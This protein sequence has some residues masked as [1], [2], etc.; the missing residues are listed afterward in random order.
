MRRGIISTAMETIDFQKKD[1]FP[2]ALSVMFEELMDKVKRNVYKSSNETRRS[3][4]KE[5][6]EN[7]IYDR[8]GIKTKV[9]LGAYTAG[10]VIP[11]LMN[12]NHSFNE[13]A[14]TWREYGL[15]AD[16]EKALANIKSKEGT[17][18][19][20]R[21][22]LGGFF[23]EFEHNM[24]L[25]VK[26]WVDIGLQPMEGVAIT[27]HEIG[28]AFTYYEFSDR[29]SS[30]NRVL[31][32]LAKEVST[33]NDPKKKSYILKDLD[34]GKKLSDSDID[35]IINSPNK[36]IIGAR[37]FKLMH[38]SVKDQMDMLYYN[39]TTSEQM[40]DN[41]AAKFGVGRY[42][43]S[44]L[45]RLSHAYFDPDKYRSLRILNT[46]IDL[47]KA[48]VLIGFTIFTL[49][50]PVL[51][52]T[53]VG[54][55]SIFMGVLGLL[56][57]YFMI[58]VGLWSERESNQ[59]MTYDHLKDRYTRVRQQAIQELKDTTLDPEY[60]KNRLQDIELIDKAIE[61]TVTYRSVFNL[62]FR[63]VS[64]DDRDAKATIEINRDLE[65][66]AN[67]DLYLMSAKLSTL[68]IPK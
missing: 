23:S 50:S 66:L 7:L 28:H 32:E 43:V 54:G 11:F 10:A 16:Q 4:Y 41:F 26:V 45:D 3:E 46:T 59:Y 13:H 8:F 9:D 39:R 55:G 56:F 65:A 2:L 22:K 15:L 37:L 17:I 31:S 47:V 67:N 30:T 51:I 34:F 60:V 62:L 38:L 52:L 42:L 20:A 12:F 57:L 24:W 61:S 58:Y 21:A 68:N 63:I 6:I 35:T 48:T 44:G 40:A 36:I 49:M 14:A 18:D 5:K 33:T 64:S 27:I 1:P 25:G 19:L 29:M 53:A